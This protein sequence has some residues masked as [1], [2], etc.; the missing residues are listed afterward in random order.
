VISRQEALNSAKEAVSRAGM[1]WEE[2]VDVHWGPFNYSIWTNAKTA[3]GN[4]T[5]RVNRRSG[6]ATIEGRTI[7]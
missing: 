1:L 4:I 2:P 6:E 7:K 5:I 3:G